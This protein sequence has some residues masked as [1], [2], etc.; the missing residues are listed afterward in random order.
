MTYENGVNHGEYMFDIFNPEG[1]FVGRKSLKDFSSHQGL[2]GKI[3]NDHF[4]CIEEK[5][6]GFQQVVVYKMKWE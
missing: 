2:N 6:S 3:R 1:V 4:Y 5:E